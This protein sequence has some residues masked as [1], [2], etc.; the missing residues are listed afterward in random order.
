VAFGSVGNRLS[1]GGLVK[2]TERRRIG[3]GLVAAALVVALVSG[4]R[5]WQGTRGWATAVTIM[6]VVAWGAWVLWSR[7]RGGGHDDGSP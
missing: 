6:V 4:V 3:V 7:Y 1:L 2:P 5:A